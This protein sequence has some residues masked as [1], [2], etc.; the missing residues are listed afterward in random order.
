MQATLQAESA[1]KVTKRLNATA[2]TSALAHASNWRR[3][4]A[5]LAREHETVAPTAVL[6][7]VRL[8]PAWVVAGYVSPAEACA[9]AGGN[10]FCHAP[11][12]GQT[13]FPPRSAR[14][15]L[16]AKPVLAGHSTC[17]PGSH[18]TKAPTT[19]QFPS[20][21]QLVRGESLSTFQLNQ[22]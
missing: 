5:I 21:S 20:V 13:A 14:S 16:A 22:S 9:G 19:I 4:H 6:G 15:P 17:L 7:L 3:E 18:A 1:G 10:C 11:A 8:A 2:T 12:D